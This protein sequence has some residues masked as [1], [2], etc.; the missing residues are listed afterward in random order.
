MNRQSKAGAQP[1]AKGSPP[2]KRESLLAGVKTEVPPPELL[3][4]AEKAKAALAFANADLDGSG[5]LEAE[6]LCAV[7]KSL[8]HDVTQQRMRELIA[9]HDSDMDGGL[10][11]I[12]FEKLIASNSCAM[13]PGRSRDELD[14]EALLEF[15]IGKEESAA[16]KSTASLAEPRIAAE[17]VA[18]FERRLATDFGITI[19]IADLC[20]GGP[21]TEE[22]IRALLLSP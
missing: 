2:F 1:S 4:P 6:E 22:K 11:L 8:G 3:S 15:C 18:E 5:V 14:T 16:S 19:R 20:D 21:V 7:L 10:S 12:E 13:D 17:K 9:P